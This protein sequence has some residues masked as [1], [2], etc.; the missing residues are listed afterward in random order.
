M[1]RRPRLPPRTRERPLMAH[2]VSSAW[3]GTVATTDVCGQLEAGEP[4]RR[5]LDEARLHHVRQGLRA[6]THIFQSR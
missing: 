6:A 2:G 1:R 5:E 3:N 4:L